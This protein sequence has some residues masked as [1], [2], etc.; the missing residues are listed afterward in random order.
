MVVDIE[1]KWG[2]SGGKEMKTEVK[3]ELEVEKA[4]EE[5]RREKTGRSS[6]KKGD[7]R[8]RGGKDV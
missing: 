3:E 6:R 2:C 8:S 7:T 4:E 5:K 1:E